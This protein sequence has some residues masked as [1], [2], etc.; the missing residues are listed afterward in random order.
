LCLCM[1]S[2]A[3]AEEHLC[4]PTRLAGRFPERFCECSTTSARPPLRRFGRKRF[5]P[6]CGIYR[7]LHFSIRSEP[8]G[9]ARSRYG[10]ASSA[11]A[12]GS[13]LLP[14]IEASSIFACILRICL[15]LPVAFL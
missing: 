3:T 12:E 4:F 1:V 15:S 9:A 11:F 14:G 7:R 10:H 5:F 13:R 2:A 6:A 8:G